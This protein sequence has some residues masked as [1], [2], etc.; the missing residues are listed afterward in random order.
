MKVVDNE[1]GQLVDV[2]PGA[3]QDAFA[4]GA[5]SLRKGQ[6]VPVRSP[7]GKLG[8]VPAEKAHEAL[9]GGFSFADETELRQAELEAKHGS[10]GELAKTVAERAASGL[11]LGLSDAAI[12]NLGGSDWAKAA[13]ERKEANPTLSTAAELGGAI[14]PVFFTGGLGA[15]GEAGAVA[16]AGEAAAAGGERML[17]S[18]AETALARAGEGGL[19]RAGEALGADVA[20]VAPTLGETAARGGIGAYAPTNL[21]SRVGESAASAARGIVGEGATTLGGKVLQRAVPM[22]AQGAAEGAFYGAGQAV[23]DAAL[24]DEDLTAEK[25]LAGTAGGALGG[26]ALGGGLGAL[27]AVGSDLAEKASFA[28]GSESSLRDW[29]QQFRDERVIKAVG[30]SKADIT[31]L[32]GITR[33]GE[34]AEQRIAEIGDTITS[35]KMPDGKPLFSIGSTT[36]Q[37]AKKTREA[38]RE[39]GAQ[40]GELRDKVAKTINEGD[41][42]AP[43]AADF[44]QNAKTQIIEPLQ[45]SLSDQSNRTARALAREL[46]PLQRAAEA[47]TLTFED[48][49]RLRQSWDAQLHPPKGS[50]GLNVAKPTDAPL[51]SLTR[52]L[53]DTIERATDAAVKASGQVELDGQYQILKR[54]FRDLRDANKMAENWTARDLGNRLA[55]PTDYATGLGGAAMALAH[56]AGGLGSIVTGLVASQV[57]HAVRERGS[58]VA[59][60]V[61][62]KILKLNAISHAVS[63]VDQRI[64]AGL[65]KLLSAGK[66]A[67]LKSV[68][69]MPWLDKPAKEPHDEFE[70]L[71]RAATQLQSNPTANAAAASQRVAAIAP[72]A[73]LVAS[74]LANA[75]GA[76]V[77]ALAKRIPPTPPS[78]TIVPRA[79]HV[80]ND[81]ARATFLRSARGADPS[82]VLSDAQEGRLSTD[83]IGVMREVTPKLHA[84]IVSSAVQRYAQLVEA[85]KDLPYER[86]LQLAKLVGHPVDDTQTPQFIATIQELHAERNGAVKQA[87]QSSPKRQIKGADRFRSYSERIGL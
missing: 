22:A 75:H 78:A 3:A 33:S 2:A 14:A 9:Q 67:G 58:V 18:G 63:A 69:E 61:A 28:F 87:E 40:L 51:N 86:R 32:S 38:A 31:A 39:V 52:S 47:G 50:G 76:A 64:E 49:T 19:A 7:D 84:Q 83:S 48:L 66:V 26:L 12:R 79:G 55:S 41:V 29:L 53:E 13:A 65:G 30:A 46:A 35:Y 42:V 8:T 57:H 37:I 24:G 80:A 62:D 60:A 73:P 34:K 25:L 6:R 11:T 21:V 1:T 68:A 82:K 45:R 59:A 23:S 81:V 56:G 44:L 54:Q 20:S 15:A 4:Q 10:A 27:G 5:A 17:T 70:R 36:E 74:A 43:I 77:Q 71:T 85:G 16:R 72:A